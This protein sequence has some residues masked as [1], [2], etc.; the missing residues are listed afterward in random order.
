MKLANSS[1]CGVISTIGSVA[2]SA[3]AV[4]VGVR[5]S[6]RIRAKEIKTGTSRQKAGKTV[7]QYY[8]Y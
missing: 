2:L 5:A 1:T 4:A 6:Q 8:V 3:A 7:G